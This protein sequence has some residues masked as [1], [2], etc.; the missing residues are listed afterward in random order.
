MC[1]ASERLTFVGGA[2]EWALQ[3]HRAFIIHAWNCNYLGIHLY[4]N[5]FINIIMF[6]TTDAQFSNDYNL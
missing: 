1:D 5:I 2:S 4:V 3:Q 6:V